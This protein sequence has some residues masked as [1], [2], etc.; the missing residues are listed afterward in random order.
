MQKKIDNVFN[1]LDSPKYNNK[2]EIKTEIDYI[3]S[4]KNKN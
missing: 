2:N 3:N 1:N 4:I